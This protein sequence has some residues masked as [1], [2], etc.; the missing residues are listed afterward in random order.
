MNKRVL[1]NGDTFFDN[2]FAS[3]AVND[4]VTYAHHKSV[5]SKS[6]DIHDVDFMTNHFR[7]FSDA[8]DPPHQ[9]DLMEQ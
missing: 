8:H 9:V 7:N 1:F 3:A 4:T 5:L 2:F 6:M